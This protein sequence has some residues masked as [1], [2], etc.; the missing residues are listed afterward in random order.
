MEDQGSTEATSINTGIGSFEDFNGSYSIEINV[1]NSGFTTAV[2]QGDVLIISPSLSMLC[3][4]NII[5]L[6][7]GSW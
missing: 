3:F 4:A 5:N 7:I 6:W 2:G 1:L